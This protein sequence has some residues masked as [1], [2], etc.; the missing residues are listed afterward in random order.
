VPNIEAKE[1]LKLDLESQKELEEFE[2][3]KKLS[4]AQNRAPRRF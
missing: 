2:N 3:R 4:K 1:M